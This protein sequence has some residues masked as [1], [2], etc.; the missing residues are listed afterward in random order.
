MTRFLVGIL[1][2]LAMAG[3]ALASD[4]KKLLDP[5]DFAAL[6]DD[7]TVLD[8][9]AP[10]A[11]A[12]GHIEGALNAPYGS[13]RGPKSNPG[14]ALTD[15]TLTERLQSLGL[16]KATPVVVIYAGK[17]VTDFGAAA[18]V[19]WTLKSAGLTK[20]AIL[21]GGLK[22]WT[23]AGN[24][25][26]NAPGTVERSTEA[27]SLSDDWMITRDGVVDVVAGRT[28]AQIIDARPVEFLQGKK[29]HKA[30]KAAGTLAGAANVQH[31]TWFTGP[32][33]VKTEITTAEDVLR[34]AREAGVEDG[35]SRPIASFCNTGHWAATN[36]F[37]LSELAGIANVKLYPESM[38][39]WTNANQPV[40]VT[41]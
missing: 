3:Q 1:M 13:W 27:F 29:K 4:W 12:E 2:V 36:W 15:V 6:M 8:I 38:V 23:G 33:K 31:S 35:Q 11:F 30:A 16:T 17:N 19:Y 28:D 37:A 14:A 20:I 34:L 18:R 26:A 24:A 9:R 21:N 41:E 40:T 5:A 10:K 32:G 22:A 39:G 7:V 25:L